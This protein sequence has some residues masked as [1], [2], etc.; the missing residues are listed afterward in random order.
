VG[1]RCLKDGPL[2]LDLRVDGGIGLHKIYA[3][4]P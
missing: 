4:D 1:R 2:R 3:V